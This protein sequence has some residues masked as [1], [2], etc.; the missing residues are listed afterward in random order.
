MI[1]FA[2]MVSTSTKVAPSMTKLP[3]VPFWAKPCPIGVASPIIVSGVVSMAATAIL[4]K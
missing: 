1:S 2:L 4:A 3:A